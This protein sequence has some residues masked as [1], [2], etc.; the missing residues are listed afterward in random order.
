MSMK[1]L[2]FLIRLLAQGTMQTST[3]VS[4]D[5]LLQRGGLPQYLPPPTILM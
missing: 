4:Q 3:R 2:D 5:I 1:F